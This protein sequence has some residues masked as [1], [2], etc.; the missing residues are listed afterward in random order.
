MNTILVPLDSSPLMDVPKYLV[1]CNPRILDCHYCEQ[2]TND[3][4]APGS[5]LPEPDAGKRT[6]LSSY[7]K[8]APKLRRS[9]YVRRQ[10]WAEFSIR[11]QFRVP[12]CESPPNP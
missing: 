4:V 2:Q 11:L 7:S 12:S 9:R 1:G 10:M 5:A 6:Q 8:L 3:Q